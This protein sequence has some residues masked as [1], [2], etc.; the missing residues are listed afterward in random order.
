MEYGNSNVLICYDNSC[1]NASV[2]GLTKDCGI[3]ELVVPL[4]WRC[5]W[6]C[7][8]WKCRNA[9]VLFYICFCSSTA[10]SD[11]V[12]EFLSLR[13]TQAVSEEVRWSHS[14]S[15]VVV[16]GDKRRQNCSDIFVV[17]CRLSCYGRC[18]CSRARC[19][20]YWCDAA[21]ITAGDAT[22]DAADVGC[23]SLKF[24][25]EWWSNNI[26]SL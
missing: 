17:S 10:P 21:V 15:V 25:F 5:R 13:V 8:W 20:W 9:I 7:Q 2:F 12:E 16:F 3:L 6:Q 19:C 26:L 22:G 11:E 4:K 1:V 18:R 24:A 23:S 14:I